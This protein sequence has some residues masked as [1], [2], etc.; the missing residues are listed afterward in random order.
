MVP[1]G[2]LQGRPG[3]SRDLPGAPAGPSRATVRGQLDALLVAPVSC[4]VPL[5][6]KLQKDRLSSLNV[7]W[8]KSSIICVFSSGSDLRRSLFRAGLVSSG[9]PEI[10]PKW[11]R[12]RCQNEVRTVRTSFWHRFR[13][14]FGTICRRPKETRPAR[15]RERRRSLPLE[16]TRMIEHFRQVT[17]REESLHLGRFLRR[18]AGQETGATRR[19]EH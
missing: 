7:T 4:P 6:K 3:G 14:H 8:R 1:G 19:A 13:G 2:L 16:K 17:L 15:K 5:L 10:V 18:G 9:R 11:P 12:N